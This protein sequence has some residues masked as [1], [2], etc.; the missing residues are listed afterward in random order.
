V[1]ARKVG[2]TLVDIGRAVGK[3]VLALAPQGSTVLGVIDAL[4]KA[5]AKMKPSQIAA[6]AVAVGALG[7][8]TGKFS[9]LKGLSLLVAGLSYAY[10][11]SNAFRT[12]ADDAGKLAAQLNNLPDVA[13]LL[14][15]GAC[16]LAL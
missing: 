4:A 1:S 15:G 8:A 10:N 5:V 14:G 11:H 6:T 13:K 7:L 16:L 2:T 12:L 3:V 9:G